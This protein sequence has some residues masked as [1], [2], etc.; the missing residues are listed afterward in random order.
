LPLSQKEIIV[1]GMSKVYD[2]KNDKPLRL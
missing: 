2:V 1:G